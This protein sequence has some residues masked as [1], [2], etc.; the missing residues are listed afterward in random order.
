MY[1]IGT[2]SETIS[3]L[4][5]F[6]NWLEIIPN[7][8]GVP[9]VFILIYIVFAIRTK[10][11]SKQK[12]MEKIGK[13]INI[14]KYVP[15]L[16]FETNETRENLRYFYNK[17]W[18]KR[19]KEYFKIIFE[20]YYGKLLK[21]IFKNNK[22]EFIIKKFEK[23]DNIDIKLDKLL[24]LFSAIQKCKIKVS[25]K[26][27]KTIY[28]FTQNMRQYI[29]YIN[30]LKQKLNL[31]NNDIVFLIGKAG[32]GKTSIVCHIC[33][34]LIKSNKKVIF[35]EIKEI[36]K[37]IKE[38]LLQNIG[39]PKM[40]LKEEFLELVYRIT[41]N[42]FFRNA[43]IFID[44]LNENK[45]LKLYDDLIN[46]YNTK[47][48]NTRVLT[49]CR[50]EYFE[51]RYKEEIIEKVSKKQHVYN[52]E[53]GRIYDIAYESM[54]NAYSKAYNYMGKISESVKRDLIGNKLLTKIFFEVY[55]DSDTDALDLDS[56][57]LFEKYIKIV[58]KEKIKKRK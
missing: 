35:L 47:P 43:Y 32:A 1:Y 39:L 51:A 15:D 44:G 21:E 16:F 7:F 13:L 55:R 42:I 17:K 38:E 23:N 22:K 31:I 58:A 40:F 36:N 57:N 41:F 24:L 2:L 12:T 5:K 52:I 34:S 33:E 10:K 6:P 20:S 26:Y 9:I 50:S 56:S 18:I 53:D 30:D 49:T 11:I 48:K 46:F 45:E 8:F 27:K 3:Y 14:N 37:N 4:K 29:E 28:L 19:I 54:L 25:E